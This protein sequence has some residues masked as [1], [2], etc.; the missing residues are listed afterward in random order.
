MTAWSGDPIPDADRRAES[1]PLEL[2]GAL[3][4]QNK[5][6]RNC[7]ALDGIGGRA[8]ARPDD[9]RHA[10]DARPAH[11]PG[12]QRHARRRQHAGLRQADEPGRD[13]RAGRVPGEPAAGG[14]AARRRRPTNRSRRPTERPSSDVAMSPTLDAFLRSWPFAPW[15]VGRAARLGRDLP[16]RLADAASPRSRALARRPARRLSR[17]AGGDLP[18]PG[19]ADR[20]VRVA[21]AAGPHAAAP[22]AD[23]G[24]AR[25]S[26][27]WAGRCS[28]CCAACREPVRT[29]WVA[30]LLRSRALRDALRLADAPARGLAALSSA[31]PGSGTRRAATS[32]PCAATAGTSS[33]TPASSPLRCCSGIRSCGR[34][35]AG[36]AGRPGCCSRTCSWPTCRTR[37]LAAWLTF[38]ADVLYPHYARVPRLGGHLG[39]RRP[40]DGRRADVGARLDRLPAAAVLDRRRRCLFGAQIAIGAERRRVAVHR[41]RL[42]RATLGQPRVRP[43][44]RFRSSGRFLR[45]RH[46]R[47]AL[48][49]AAGRRW[50]RWSSSTASRA[51]RSA[52]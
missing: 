37:V 41:A 1:T 49:A 38:S 7:H 12:Q 44:A 8:R 19:V 35:R 17:R 31:R 22:A 40:G 43:A 25:R 47:V 51:R 39:A 52:R 9:G 3:V 6:C 45:W 21:A 11:R 48:Q 16:A 10:A 4:F 34:I 18:R 2:Q 28:R 24:R 5:N 32:W 30:P 20:A 23:D 33:S 42:A 46:A 27:G 15:L 14:P 29:Y 26:S 13:G 50:R 36:R